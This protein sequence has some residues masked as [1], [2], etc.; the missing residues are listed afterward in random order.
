MADNKHNIKIVAI[1]GSVNPKS[2]TTKA[3]SLV[4][5][6]LKGMSDVQLD[7]I[8]PSEMNLTLPGEAPS[9]A[10]KDMQE[11]VEQATGVIVTTPEYHG[12]YS[13]TIKLVI[14]NLGYPSMLAGKPIGL[15]GVAAGQ[16]GAVKALEHLRSVCSHVGG[17][18]LPGP[19]SVA[20][21]MNVFDEEGNCIDE[22]TEKR[23]RALADNLVTYIKKHICPGKA[24]ED[25]VRE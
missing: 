17:I 10:A 14:D 8:D 22:S 6:Q 24:L 15:L 13:S 20:S 3:L 2:Y 12:S 21:V 1:L 7:V 25:L 5:D 19:V 11:I 4:E 18:V 23:I 9:S 16:I